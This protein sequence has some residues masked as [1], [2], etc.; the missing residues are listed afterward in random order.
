MV[1][2]PRDWD[3]L[4]RM[5]ASAVSAHGDG[6][7][8]RVWVVPRSSRSEISGRHG[9]KIRVRVM[10]PPEGGRA[11]DE[12]RRLLS[13]RLGAD[14]ELVSGATGRVKVFLARGVELEEVVG[15][16]AR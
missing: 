8:L 12:V 14:V 6:V 9:D 1:G 7:M 13:R 2:V 15:K 11:N 16:L 3:S 10:A 4:S 5:S